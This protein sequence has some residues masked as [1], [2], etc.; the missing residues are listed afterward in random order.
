MKNDKLNHFE[1]RL[2]YDIRLERTGYVANN[3]YSEVYDI[4]S[5][6]MLRYPNHSSIFE[7]ED[8]FARLEL[9]IKDTATLYLYE[10]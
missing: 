2:F 7:T 1:R 9:D 6:E 10:K 4:D 5:Q 3:H 8:Y